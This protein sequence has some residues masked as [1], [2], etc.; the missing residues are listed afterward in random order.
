ME[1]NQLT[2]TIIELCIKI[3]STIGPGCF[4]RVYEDLLY[5]EIQ[6]RDIPLQRQLLMPICYE[7]LRIQDAYKPDLLVDDRLIVEIK[8]VENVLGVHYKQLQTYLKLMKLKNGLLLN[9]KVDLM[10]N[11]VHRVFNNFG[12]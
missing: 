6:K 12:N 10:K 9:F 11:G 3:H 8:S 7:E 2:G 5:Y 4:E 1:I